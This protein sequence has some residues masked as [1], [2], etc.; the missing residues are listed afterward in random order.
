MSWV[1]AQGVGLAS[2]EKCVLVWCA[3]KSTEQLILWV[4][5]HLQFLKFYVPPGPLRAQP[6]PWP[7]SVT[8]PLSYL[9]AA[10]PVT[11]NKNRQSLSQSSVECVRNVNR[12]NNL[13]QKLL[14]VPVHNLYFCVHWKDVSGMKRQWSVCTSAGCN[15]AVGV[16]LLG[17]SSFS[18]KIHPSQKVLMCRTNNLQHT[19]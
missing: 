13:Q 12:T 14:A 17:N 3:P 8:F 16:P 4:S 10:T 9:N 2:E 15:N 1:K 7:L 19:I 11:L 18:L 5:N 6:P